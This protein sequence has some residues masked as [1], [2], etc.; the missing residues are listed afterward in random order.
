MVD[1]DAILSRAM[2]PAPLILTEDE[3]CACQRLNLIARA[4]GA[5]LCFGRVV[6]SSL[7]DDALSTRAVATERAQVCDDS[8][9]FGMGIAIGMTF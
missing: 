4:G 5:M 8:A 6:G 2:S 1:I 3:L 7:V 9:A